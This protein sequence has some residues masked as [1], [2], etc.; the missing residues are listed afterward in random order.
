MDRLLFNTRNITDIE[1]SDVEGVGSL[2]WKDGKCYRWVK[3]IEGS[4][5]LTVGH[6]V[7][8]DL[9]LAEAMLESV[10]IPATG[11]LSFLGGV[12]VSAVPKSQFGWIQCLGMNVQVSV[13]NT[14]NVTVVAGDNVKAVA[15]QG[16]LERDSAYTTLPTYI[17]HIRI[18]EELAT[19]TSTEC[20]AAAT[21]CYIDCL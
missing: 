11:D 8:H 5:S 9:T 19:V 18:L 13:T 12:A 10:L 15:A 14:T 20:A 21:K 2:R 3:N 16:Y 4:A 7:C 1:T 17:R 6:G